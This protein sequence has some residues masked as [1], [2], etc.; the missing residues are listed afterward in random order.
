MGAQR[1][2]QARDE[3]SLSAMAVEPGAYFAV[4]ESKGLWTYFREIGTHEKGVYAPHVWVVHSPVSVEFTGGPEGNAARRAFV[5]FRL[6]DAAPRTRI[7]LHM[8]TGLPTGM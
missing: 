3:R 6:G 5:M 2:R 7:Q 8:R 4:A 1:E